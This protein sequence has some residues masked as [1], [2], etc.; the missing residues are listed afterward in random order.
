MSGASGGAPGGATAHVIRHAHA[1]S[2]SQWRGDDR[3][4]PLSDKGQAQADAVAVSLADAGITEVWTS[5][6]VR[7][8]QTVEPLAAKV[9][10]TVLEDARLAE[11]GDAAGV[12]RSLVEAV[13][14]GRTVA[15]CSHGDVIPAMVA[16]AVRAGAHLH[17]PSELRKAARYQFTVEAGQVTDIHHTDRPEV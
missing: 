10:T 2:R 15:L 5:P 14:A 12:L 9:G 3:L 4:R 11:D 6:Y 17:G 8:V 1:G 13:E 16:A 7:C